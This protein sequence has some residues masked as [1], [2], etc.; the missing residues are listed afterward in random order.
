[1]LR[2]HS[3]FHKM[4][5]TAFR[6]IVILSC[7]GLFLL[8][9]FSI[10][11]IGSSDV[12]IDRRETPS[13]NVAPLDDFIHDMRVVLGPVNASARVWP[14]LHNI[15]A[16]PV[17]IRDG[18]VFVTRHIREKMMV[19]P[20]G[21]YGYVRVRSVVE[22]IKTGLDLGRSEYLPNK[23]SSDLPVLLM[24]GDSQGCHFKNKVDVLN[25]PRVG[26]SF[27]S[28]EGAN[29]SAYHRMR[30]GIHSTTI[31]MNPT[32]ICNSG[33]NPNSTPGQR[34]LTKQ[35]GVVGQAVILSINSHL[36]S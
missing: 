12:T 21:E 35:C 7:S 36:H 25:Y 27:P 18:Q 33:S 13:Q 3:N 9:R 15:I 4:I 11:S 29:P 17:I 26:W 2:Y 32:G 16:V 28:P 24:N 30:F 14:M 1:M 10:D 5:V 19:L 23:F 6:L 31:R 34:R 20:P 8:R 22:M